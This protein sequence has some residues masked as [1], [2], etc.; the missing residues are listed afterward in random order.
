MRIDFDNSKTKPNDTAKLVAE[1]V[2]R[3]DPL[4]LFEEFYKNQNNVPMSE[5]QNDIMKRLLF[6]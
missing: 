5:E 3:K 2:I 1:D 6:E 4:S